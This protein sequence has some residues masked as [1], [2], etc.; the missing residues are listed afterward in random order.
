MAGRRSSRPGCRPSGSRRG[1]PG[2]RGRR[3]G[4]RGRR[5]A[6]A[7]PPRR[8]RGRPGVVFRPR[9]RQTCVGSASTVLTGQGLRLE[10]QDLLLLA[11][12]HGPTGPAGRARRRAGR[13][14]CP[15]G[16]SRPGRRPCTT[17]SPGLNAGGL[18]R[19]ARLDVGEDHRAAALRRGGPRRRPGRA[20]SR[21][22]GGCSSSR[23]R[24]A[25]RRRSAGRTRSPAP[26]PGRRR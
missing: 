16:S 20:R 14:R 4:R 25:S 8:T 2:C 10:R 6:W 19:A 1:R 24:P 26:R 12:S 23:R 11:A 21:R 18:G 3:P 5:G 7:R 15:A 22:A 13:A 9:S 17:W